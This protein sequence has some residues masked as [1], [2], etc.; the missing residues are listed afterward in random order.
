MNNITYSNIK[1]YNLYE[2][3]NDYRWIFDAKYDD[4]KA[5]DR[6]HVCVPLKE[7]DSYEN[8]KRV[9]GGLFLCHLCANSSKESA[10]INGSLNIVL[11]GLGL[12]NND[13]VL[14]L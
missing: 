8:N 4:I 9:D 14:T 12:F 1:Q 6:C 5:C 2:K 11:I 10:Q 7:F 13:D 3:G